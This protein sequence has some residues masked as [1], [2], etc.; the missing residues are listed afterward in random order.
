MLQG[1]YQT[2]TGEIICGIPTI[3]GTVLGFPVIRILVFGR[4]L[5]PH[6]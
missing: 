1:F 2:Q 4:S 5:Y 6:P 3:R